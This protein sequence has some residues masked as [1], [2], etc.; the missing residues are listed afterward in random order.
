MGNKILV[1]LDGGYGRAVEGLGDLVSYIPDFFENPNDYCLVLFTGGE[2]V[3][4]FLYGETSPD[5]LCYNSPK[6]DRIEA[7]IFNHALKHGIR[8]TGIC[9]GSQFIN[10]MSG[11]RMLHHIENHSCYHD[12][13][14]T[15]GEIF[16]T[17]STHHQMSIPPKDGFVI[18]WCAKNRS[19][20]YIGDKDL[21]VEWNG[22][23]TEMIL[24]PRTLCCG[25]QWHPETMNGKS[26]GYIYYHNLIARFLERNIDTFAAEYV[27]IGKENGNIL[28]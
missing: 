26:M 11:G 8:M 2:D 10:V 9:R 18:G 3:S 17:N 16:E 5:G 4:P 27:K 24:I 19:S 25:V 6:R 28:G 7:A 21:P 20:I 13:E 12:V 23:E 22:P 15:K 14:T 1:P